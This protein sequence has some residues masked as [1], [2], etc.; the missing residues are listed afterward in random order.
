MENLSDHER[1]RLA[2]LL[3]MHFGRRGGDPDPADIALLAKLLGK[4]KAALDLFLDD[5]GRP[6]LAAGDE[7]KGAM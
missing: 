3:L 4:P 1:D 2:G 7:N 6:W 5:V